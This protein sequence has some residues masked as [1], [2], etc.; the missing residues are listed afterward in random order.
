MKYIFDGATGTYILSLTHYKAAPERLCIDDAQ[1]VA[2]VHREYIEAGATAIKTNT[3]A[4]YSAAGG[5]GA[6]LGEIIG[7][8][9][10]IAADACAGTAAVPFADIGP[11]PCDNAAA[12]YDDIVDRFLALGATRFLFETHAT[13][14][15]LF[16]CVR[17][18]RSIRSD[19]EIIVSFAVGQDGYTALGGFYKHLI[20]TARDAGADIAG[21]NCVCGPA[22]M[23]ELL[24]KLDTTLPVTAMPN[25][26]YPSVSGG[27]TVYIDS[28][29]YFA[30]RALEMCRLGVAVVGGCCGTTPAHIRALTT[31]LS[32]ETLPQPEKRQ[33]E[34]VYI[35]T[36]AETAYHKSTRTIAIELDPPADAD[37][38][39]FD[40]AARLVGE[41]VAGYVTVPDSPLARARADAV[42]LSARV[43]RV[44]GIRAIPHMTCRDRNQIALKGALVAGWI[45]GLRSVLAVTGDSAA[46]SAVDA[47]DVYGMNSFGLIAYISSLNEELFASEPYEIFAALNTGAQNFDAELARAQ[48][49][50]DAGASGFMTQPVFTERQADNL[51]RAKEALG[52]KI[53]AG[54]MPVAGYK[55]ACFLQNEVAG[56]E[57]PDSFIESLRGADAERTRELSV[58]YCRGVIDE[59]YNSCDGF[60][61]MTPRKKVRFA[62]DLA[63]YIENKDKSGECPCCSSA[64]N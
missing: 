53:L 28:P 33:S 38:A 61:I 5:D 36:K 54:I 6:L 44:A 24:E 51:R 50:I 30:Q 41:S 45:E 8:A 39:A 48:K 3:F 42:A 31:L 63:E 18:L 32:K 56:I 4:A 12:A 29:D 62:L 49:K 11:V 40:E 57:L 25:A 59:I 23:L 35:A 43:Q 60:Y 19:A 1:L 46:R 9:W 52:A 55:N 17:R 47:K 58:G 37:V 14:N 10:R 7:A 21:I 20:A 64:K 15:G 34:S 16:D 26:G 2:R 27:R 13:D 22:H